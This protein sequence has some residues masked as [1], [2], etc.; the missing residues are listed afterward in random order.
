VRPVRKVVWLVPEARE[1]WNT[2]DSQIGE[3]ARHCDVVVECHT[4]ERLLRALQ[5]V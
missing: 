1:R 5:R 3:Y 2:G 4:L